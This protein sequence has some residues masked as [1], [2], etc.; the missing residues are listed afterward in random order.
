MEEAIGE[1]V[2]SGKGVYLMKVLGGGSLASD[3]KSAM[4]YAFSIK[5]VHSISLGMV[6]GE[7]LSYNINYFNSE[8]REKL[9]LPDIKK[10]KKT[11]KVLPFVC[12]LCKTCFKTCPNDAIEEK[13]SKAFINTDKCLTCGYCVGACPTFAIRMI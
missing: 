9:D 7:E 4:E 5:G 3:Y 11:F 6:S 2:K 12:N 13:D 8:N 10:L 1:C